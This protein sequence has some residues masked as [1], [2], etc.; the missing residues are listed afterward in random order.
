[1]EEPIDSTAQ[2]TT[3]SDGTSQ[4][5]G[6]SAPWVAQ[7]P[8]WGVWDAVRASPAL[9]I[10]TV[11]V[12]LG[13]GIV[14]AFVRHP[15]Y[16]ATT[17]L[18]VLHINLASAGAINGLSTAAPAL[19]D[20]YA[21]AIDADGVVRPLESQFHSSAVTLRAE[22]AA[23]AI[24]LSPVFT[25]TATTTSKGSAIALAN[26]ATASLTAYAKTVNSTNPDQ[27]RLFAALS[28][29]NTN[30]AAADARHQSL[31]TSIQA[32]LAGKRGAASAPSS[33]Q[34]D[35]LARAQ[36]AINDDAAQANSLRQAYQLNI[37]GSAT[38][39]YLQQ[40][41]GATTAASDR[42][43]KLALLGFAGAVVGLGLG[44][45]LALLR[46]ARRMRTLKVA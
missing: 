26:S 14:G 13:I 30:L 38:T 18:A 15:K 3:R 11:L 28:T 40:L 44:V 45:G 41:Q 25:V 24:P 33:A 37:I 12:C 2:E 23:A 8:A 9:V 35:E 21:R 34:R 46:Y 39:Q 16:T 27:A 36:A 5:P 43:S 10:I 7:Q 32:S 31:T 6:A 20:T 29:A 22:L 17:K 1:M 19:A 42:K 4:P